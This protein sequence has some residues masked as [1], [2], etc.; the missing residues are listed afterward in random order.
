MIRFIIPIVFLVIYS[1][2]VN[3]DIPVS[4]DSKPD[5]KTKSIEKTRTSST[6]NPESGLSYLI[7]GDY[8][9]S[10]VP[11]DMLSRRFERGVGD[12]VWFRDGDNGLAPYQMNVFSTSSEVAVINGNCFTCHAGQLRGQVIPGLGDSFGTFDK[13]LKP[14]ADATYLGVRLRYGKRSSAWSSFED[15]GR[16]FKKMSPHIRTTQPGVNPAF[17]LAEACMMHRNPSDLRYESK[18]QFP[19]SSFPLATDVPP[20][21]LVKKK[22]ALYYSAIGRGDFSKL[23]FQASVLGIHDSLQARKALT[24]FN[25]V[26]AWLE[27]LTPPPY[28]G[29][30]DQNKA[31][32]GKA[33]FV[34]HCSGCHGTYGQ[35]SSYP[36]KVVALEQIGT[37]PAYVHY[38]QSSGIVNWYNNSWFAQSEPKSWFE[39]MPGYIAPP[40]DGIWATAPYLHNGSVPTIEALLH[41]KIR[42]TIWIRSGDSHDYDLDRLGWRYDTREKSSKKGWYYDTRQPGYGNKGHTFG[43]KLS[44]QERRDILEYLKTL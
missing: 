44:D 26:V 14:F 40:L 2:G 4:A 17:R 9:G 27:H 41:S 28:P 22:N 3:Q 38:L 1:C 30:I 33:L 24:G 36:N 34:E 21:W 8:I 6:G 42:P 11:W 39:P 13:N 12:T 37:D 20:L 10:G 7:Y 15:F 19:I 23:I 29:V 32:R 16:F 43:D 5:W 31:S 25:D 18:P 35:E